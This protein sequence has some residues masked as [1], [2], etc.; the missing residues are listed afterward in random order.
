VGG[1]HG[2]DDEDEDIRVHVMS[3]EQS[4]AWLNEGVINNAAAII[5]LQ[6]LW[7]NKQQLREKWAE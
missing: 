6:W 2:L 4:I 3:L 1:V 5:A 7:I